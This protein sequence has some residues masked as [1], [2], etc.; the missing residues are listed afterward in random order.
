MEYRS[1]VHVVGG[2]DGAK[3]RTGRKASPM[4]PTCCETCAASA[5]HLGRGWKV[6]VTDPPLRA[7]AAPKTTATQEAESSPKASRQLQNN[8]LPQTMITCTIADCRIQLYYNSIILRPT[9]AEDYFFR[10]H[11][12]V[13]IIERETD[14]CNP[15]WDLH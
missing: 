13:R 9:H 11:P 3:Y 15:R 12:G 14:P 5:C 4:A 8:G 2:D 6:W 1:G 10:C 7:I